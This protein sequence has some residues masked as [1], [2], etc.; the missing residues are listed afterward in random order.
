MKRKVIFLGFFAIILLISLMTL[1]DCS[2]KKE[3]DYSW[4]EP[5][6]NSQIEKI[7]YRIKK[8]TSTEIWEVYNIKS[9]DFEN[10]HF[11]A[12]KLSGLG[13]TDDCI[14]VWA[15]SGDKN[16]PSMVFSVNWVAKEFSD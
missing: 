7:K 8:E 15:I 1:M 4:V 16:N 13:I 9:K 10:D 3:V 11:C 14:G 12:T 2:G 5:T 6:S